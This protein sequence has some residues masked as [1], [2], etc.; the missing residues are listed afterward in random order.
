MTTASTEATRG[1][2]IS[3]AAQLQPMQTFDPSEPAMLHDRRTNNIET[4]TGD[5]VSDYKENSVERPD[6]TV[7]WSGFIF[8][9][10]GEVLGG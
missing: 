4:W 7:E 8:D 2:L 5:E 1:T 9:G 6:G 3:V 10:R